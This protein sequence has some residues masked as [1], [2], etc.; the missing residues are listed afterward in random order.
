MSLCY[1]NLWTAV[2][3]KAQSVII[4][5]VKQGAKYPQENNTKTGPRH[6]GGSILNGKKTN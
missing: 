1:I 5:C 3:K 6:V 2:A 4:T